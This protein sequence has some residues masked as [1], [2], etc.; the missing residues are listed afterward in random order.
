MITLSYLKSHWKDI[1]RFC[2]FH[3]LGIGELIQGVLTFQNQG[4]GDKLQ[5]RF[6]PRPTWPH[7]HPPPPPPHT[8]T[9]LQKHISTFLHPCA[10]E[11]IIYC[12]IANRTPVGFSYYSFYTQG[13][14]VELKERVWALYW[15]RAAVGASVET[16][17]WGDPAPE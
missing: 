1:L 8:H 10:Q 7:T 13:N 4:K 5:A 9:H 14:V 16:S 3:G 11:A 15:G 17:S 6:C 12:I 2:S